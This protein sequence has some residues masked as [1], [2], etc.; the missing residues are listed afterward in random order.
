M[1][2]IH[3]IIPYKEHGVWVFDDAATGLAKEPFVSGMGEIIDRLV[4][5]RNEDYEAGFTMLFSA[6]P[7]P[8]AT[9]TLLR[10]ESESGG[11]WYYAQKYLMRGWLCPALFLYF[12][13]APEELYVQ[14][15]YGQSAR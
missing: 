15:V 3:M 4:L 8:G 7:F 13:Y 9:L 14:A 10:R 2:A 12:D 11:T 5:G 1:N 6:R